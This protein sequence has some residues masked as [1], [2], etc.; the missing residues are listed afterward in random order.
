MSSIEILVS[1]RPTPRR[2]EFPGCG[3]LHKSKGYCATHVAQLRRGVHLSA[4]HLPRRKHD[5]CTYPEC[6]RVRHAKGYCDAHYVQLKRGESLRAIRMKKNSC[7]FLGCDRPHACKGYCATHYRQWW[8][9][10][11]LSVI[12][13]TANGKPKMTLEEKAKRIREN[14]WRH[15]GITGINFDIWE[16]DAKRGCLLQFLGNCAGQLCAHH[17]H[18]SSLY[19]GPLCLLHNRHLAGLGDSPVNLVKVASILRDFQELR[20]V[21]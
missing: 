2:C 11:P 4:I 18:D 21:A 5:F 3:R 13:S 15:R 7:G 8:E 1:R 10:K 16:R 9:G 14:G 20:L 17:E 6:G 12:H 19:I